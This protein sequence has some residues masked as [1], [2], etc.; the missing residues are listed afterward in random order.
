MSSLA[1]VVSSGMD[2]NGTADDTLWADELDQLVGL[3]AL[4]ISLSISLEVSEVTNVA[5][6]VV[7]GTV[8]LAVWVDY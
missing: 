6:F 3:A 1:K 7:W 8:L 4:A 5:G 2:D